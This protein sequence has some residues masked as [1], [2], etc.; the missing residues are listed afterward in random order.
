MNFF[1]ILITTILVVGMSTQVNATTITSFQNGEI[2]D[3]AYGINTPDGIG[4]FLV[5]D[6][7]SIFKRVTIGGPFTPTVRTASQAM[8][9]FQL[10]TS[11][12][13]SALFEWDIQN[14]HGVSP[15][16]VNIYGMKPDSSLSI[17][18][19]DSGVLLGNVNTS[20]LLAGDTLSLDISSFLLGYSGDF[21]IRLE[22]TEGF[23]TEANSRL[24]TFIN[25]N[26]RV[27]VVPV[28]TAVW[29]FG[30][31]LLGLLGMRR[32]IKA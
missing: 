20:G 26:A 21:G 27:T 5:L 23:N 15:A 31:G 1:K 10:P 2:L 19:Y 16:S 28:P 13:G 7:S 8:S 25:T 14:V 9:Y 22:T 3:E 11:S 18:D 30:T 29:L 12:T 4:D 17:D 6:T 32:K 24:L